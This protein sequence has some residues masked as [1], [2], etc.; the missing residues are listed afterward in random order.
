MYLFL[1]KVEGIEEAFSCFLVHKTEPVESGSKQELQNA[2]TGLPAEQQEAAV[3][4]F[5]SMAATMTNHS[6]LQLMLNLLEYLVNNNVI[7]A[8]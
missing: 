3:K 6:Q 4:Q 1:Q 7:S 2:L 5:L 8:R